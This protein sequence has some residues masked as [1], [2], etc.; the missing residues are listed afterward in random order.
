MK[1]IYFAAVAL[2]SMSA[3]AHAHDTWVETNTNVFRVGDSAHIDL[4]LG[5]HGNE[6]RDFKL[7][8]KLSLEGCKMEVVDPG[9]KH[10][11]VKSALIDTGYTP[12]EGY[13]TTSFAAD[14]AGLYTVFQTSDA[15]MT[16][17][18]E[19]SIKTAKTFFLV[20]KS[21]DRVPADAPGFERKLGNGLELVPESNPVTPMGPGMPLKLRLYFKGK[22]LA[23]AKISFIPEGETL[24]GD[25]DAR[26]EAKTNVNGR[27]S[28]TPKEGNR[29]LAVAHVETKENG[30]D[31]SGQKY[32]FTKYGATLSVYVPQICPC[33][34]G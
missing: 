30:Q 24:K 14:K 8:S 16:Y 25:F 5:N 23:N 28:F 10:F 17:A 19:R 31:A 11:D 13:W 15:V 3:A 22:P 4:K 21:L 1:N 33:C 12:K 27:A 26:Y 6:H 2:I 20:S 32:D 18:P 7:A 9:G 34:G 29:Y